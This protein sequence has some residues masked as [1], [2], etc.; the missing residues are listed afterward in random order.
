[1]KIVAASTAGVFFA[2]SAPA[3]QAA[4]ILLTDAKIV[5]GELVVS[6][7]TQPDRKVVLDDQFGQKA[8]G[9]GGFVFRLSDYRPPTCIVTLTAG[10]A[11]ATGVVANWGPRGVSPRGA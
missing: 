3:A 1:M 9:A 4:S 10:D 8:N 5:G 7:K 11:R 6:G 2:W